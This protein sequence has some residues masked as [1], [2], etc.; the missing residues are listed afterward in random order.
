MSTRVKKEDSEKYRAMSEYGIKGGD[1]EIVAE[2]IANPNYSV[3]TKTVTEHLKKI[4][5]LAQ[6][7]NY[8]DVSD[9]YRDANKIILNSTNVSKSFDLCIGYTRNREDLERLL[10]N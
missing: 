10:N 9:F 2:S 6:E 4:V 8:D 1:K 3:V 5:K 7:N